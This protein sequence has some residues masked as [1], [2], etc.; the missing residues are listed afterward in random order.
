[1]VDKQIIPIIYHGPLIN[2]SVNIVYCFLLQ[3]RRILFEGFQTNFF[4]ILKIVSVIHL[5]FVLNRGALQAVSQRNWNT[6]T[7]KQSSILCDFVYSCI[8]YE[9]IGNMK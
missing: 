7:I 3:I 9:K 4:L 2:C 8:K 5:N 1:M 6:K